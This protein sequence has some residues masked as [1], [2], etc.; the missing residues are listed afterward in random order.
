MTSQPICKSCG[1]PIYGAY[2]A[3]L[4]EAWHP[5]HFI[6]A[7]C[8]RPISDKEY[9]RHQGVVFHIT[10]FQQHIADR[11]ACCGKPLLGPYLVDQWGTK[12]CTAHRDELLACRFCGRLISPRQQGRRTLN[13]EEIRCPICRSSA[14]EA[15][16][17]ARPLFANLVQW[18]NGQGLWF[19][20][21]SLL[22]ELR[23][24]TQ[25]AQF[26]REPGDTRALGAT[27]H[28]TITQNGTLVR[29]E[30]RG[31]AILRGLPRTLFEG[32]TV[33]EL[34]HAWLAVHGVVGLPPWSEEG[35]CEALA[36][37]FYYEQRTAESRFYLSLIENSVDPI[38][39][40]GFRRVRAIARQC[41]WRTLLDTLL[42]RKELPNI[43]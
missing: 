43:H 35:F 29:C 5:E 6:C 10:C 32:V 34:G 30:V 3:A 28:S 22:I 37:R 36:F 21:L 13:G 8:Q 41:S 9:Y 27:L 12:F 17:Q 7:H 1:Q 20:D 25:L 31:V 18:V 15:I 11:C 14:I 42:A 39:G 23:N 24:R 19:N 33:H 16:A 26:L 38:Y 4:G 2:V 40:E